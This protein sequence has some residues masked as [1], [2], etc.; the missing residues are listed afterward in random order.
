MAKANKRKKQS[1]DKSLSILRGNEPKVTKDNYKIE[2]I[3]ALNWHNVNWEEKDYRKAVTD[4]LKKHNMKQYAHCVQKADFLEIRNIGSIGRLILTGQHVDLNDIEKIAIRLE[5]LNHKY[6]R[7][8][9]PVKAK[10]VTTVPVSIQERILEQAR[11]LGGDFEGAVDEFLAD[12]KVDFSAKA[13]LLTNQVSGAVAKKIGEMFKPIAAELA[14]AVAGKDAQLKE[15]YSNLPK[16]KLKKLTAFVQSIVDDC[17]QQT[18]SAKAQRKPRARKVKPPSVIV[19]KVKYLRECAELKLKSIAPE[20]IV[21][22]SELWTY[23]PSTRKLAVFYAADNGTLSV[24]GMSI[25]NYDVAASEVKTLRKPDEFFKGLTSTGKRA[26]ANAWKALK[27]KTSKPR[28][29]ISEE[30][31]LLAAN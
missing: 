19:K 24:S 29:R 26:M 21:G 12:E 14:E 20:K 31:L 4:Y 3:Q 10:V 28:S 6:P 13:Y 27:A 5:E 1:L 22:A 11:T 15:A 25:T 8:A 18:V 30:V 16:S 7:T 17:I 23:N 9:T 2:L